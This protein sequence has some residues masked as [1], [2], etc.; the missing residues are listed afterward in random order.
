MVLNQAVS[1]M[2]GDLVIDLGEDVLNEV[3]CGQEA[4]VHFHHALNPDCGLFTEVPQLYVRADVTAPVWSNGNCASEVALCFDA[5]F[6]EAELPEPCDFEFADEC[7]EEVLAELTETV[8]AGDLTNNPMPPSVIQ[9]T[10][11][12]TDCGGNAAN[13]VQTLTLMV[14]P[15]QRLLP[16][17][18]PN[19]PSPKFNPIPVP[20]ATPWNPTTGA[21]L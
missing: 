2:T 15:A 4:T 20:E 12:G 3:P 10:Y 14:R 16:H 18:S 19:R 9:R 13:F 11:T 6:G 8:V 5:E 1:G 17:R 7:S 21:P